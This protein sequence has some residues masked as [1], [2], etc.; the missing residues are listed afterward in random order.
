MKRC[1]ARCVATAR[2]LAQAAL[3]PQRQ[4]LQRALEQPRRLRV[5]AAAEH[6]ARLPHR[7]HSLGRSHRRAGDHVAVPA[8][9]LGRAVDD[10]VG[11]ERQR[12]LQD[13]GGERVVDDEKRAGG[14]GLGRQPLEVDDA[15]QR[16][17]R[18]LGVDDPRLRREQRVDPVDVAQR[19]PVDVEPEPRR[20]RV[21]ELEGAAVDLALGEDAIARLQEGQQR[22]G[23]R[24]HA[25]GERQ[26]RLGALGRGEPRLEGRDRGIVVARV[27]HARGPGMERLEHRRER[28]KAERRALVDGRVHRA[29]L[30]LELA[31]VNGTRRRSRGSGAM[32]PPGR[33]CRDLWSGDGA[34][35]VGESLGGPWST[36]QPTPVRH[37]ARS[38][39]FSSFARVSWATCA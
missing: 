28:G 6:L 26:R 22:R 31:A 23:D 38:A 1:A 37:P 10:D 36:R 19:E 27:D 9:V 4:R 21:Q 7:V 3:E 25:R 8:Q 20:P 32:R 34:A 2:A 35:N 24:R 30:V 15:Q 39:R 29:I 11:A 13:A 18:R 16:V 17:R 12:P 33:C 14:V 5:D